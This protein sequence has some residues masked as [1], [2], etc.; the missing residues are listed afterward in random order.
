LISNWS[1]SLRSSIK[2]H[3]V[4]GTLAIQQKL[5]K[6]IENEALPKNADISIH[7][8]ISTIEN[9][10]RINAMHNNTY[11]AFPLTGRS[12]P[13]LLWSD[14]ELAI[15][16]WKHDILKE[17]LQNLVYQ[18]FQPRARDPGWTPFDQ[19]AITQQDVLTWI[20]SRAP[21]SI[22]EQFICR[23][24]PIG[25]GRSMRRQVG[26]KGAIKADGLITIQ[27]HLQAVQSDTFDPNDYNIK[28]YYLQGTIVVNT[29]KVHVNV[30]K[31]RALNRV[32]YK[33]LSPSSPY[34]T[35]HNLD[36]HLTEIRN[37][38]KDRS[39]FQ[40]FFGDIDPRDVT[41]AGIDT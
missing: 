27:N 12:D 30:F 38:I 26:I 6:M 31:L 14:R 1:K 25:Q 2:V 29:V 4:N 17:K 7:Q 33:K 39:N 21:G 13:C 8:D 37:V 36:R 5:V 20:G 15:L 19:G 23:V 11:K 9:F 10:Y 18:E 34:S 32:K 40:E 16:F 41:I 3:F 28:G 22:I 24:G 35:T